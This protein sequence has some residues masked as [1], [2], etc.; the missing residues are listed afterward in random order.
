M[1][2]RK[3]LT[4]GPLWA[5]ALASSSPADTQPR[6]EC[7]AGPEVVAAGGCQSASCASVDGPGDLS[8]AA[9]GQHNGVFATRA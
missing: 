4:P 2:G 3:G 1:I 9:T 5:Q 7:H 8:V 6:P